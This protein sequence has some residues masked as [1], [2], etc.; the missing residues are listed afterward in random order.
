MR[1]V[2]R[3]EDRSGSAREGKQRKIASSFPNSTGSARKRLSITL[4]FSGTGA[5]TT[6]EEFFYHIFSPLPRQGP[7]CAAATRK[8]FSNLTG[9]PPD[10]RALDVGCGT[11]T[12]TLDLARLLGGTIIAVDNHR[13]FLSTLHARALVQGVNEKI[14]TVKASMEALPFSAGQF[15]LIWSEGAIYLMGFEKGLASWRS[16]CKKGGYLVV[17]D[18]AWFDRDPPD[19]QVRFWELEGCTLYREE[20]KV[21]QVR[22]AGLR[23][24][25]TFR[26]PESGWWDHYYAPMLGRVRTLMEIHM[27]NPEFMHILRSCEFETE[28]YQKYRRYFGYTFFIMQNI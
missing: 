17:S 14:A 21:G 28:I 2:L 9:L 7:G 6:P 24:V 20:E 3:D 1:R 13:P 25:A 22:D 26:L 10:A 5:I 15:D 11:G 18:I 16:L 19:E 4:V 12:Q 23:L 27:E 8:A